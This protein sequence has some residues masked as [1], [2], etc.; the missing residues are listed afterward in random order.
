MDH[1]NNLANGLLKENL[2]VIRAQTATSVRRKIMSEEYGQD[3]EEPAEYEYDDSFTR[4]MEPVTT[5]I[6]KAIDAKDKEAHV[7]AL[8]EYDAIR[9]EALDKMGPDGSVFMIDPDLAGNYSD[10]FKSKHGFRPRSD[11][12][13]TFRSAIDFYKE[14]NYGSFDGD[15]SF[16]APEPVSHIED[17]EEAYGTEEA[18]AAEE[19]STGVRS[20]DGF[21]S[22]G[23]SVEDQEEASLNDGERRA[24]S[25]A[26]ELAGETDATQGKMNKAYGNLMNKV[27]G[28]VDAVANGLK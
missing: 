1:F 22:G 2:N 25:V 21:F 11:A 18:V 5:A 13:T 28:K 10:D 8:Q 19:E 4:R 6:W 27:T 3:T 16:V 26:G 12:L 15:D 7:L 20:L 9:D 24:V 14:G 17:Q 23:A